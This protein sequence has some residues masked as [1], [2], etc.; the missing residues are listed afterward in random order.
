MKRSMHELLARWRFISLSVC[1]SVRKK[2][3]HSNT[4]G[5]ALEPDSSSMLEIYVGFRAGGLRW[6][7]AVRTVQLYMLS[8]KA[9]RLIAAR[10]NRIERTIARRACQSKRSLWPQSVPGW[11]PSFERLPSASWAV[12]GLGVEMMALC[13]AVVCCV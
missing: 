11:Q 1:A 7:I 13:C 6:G 8:R 10:P 4:A 3:E 12:V 9:N 5:L 2:L